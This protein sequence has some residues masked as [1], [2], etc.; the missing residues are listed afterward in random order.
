M[1]WGG[2]FSSIESTVFIMKS[3]HILKKL[4]SANCKVVK[5]RDRTI[6]SSTG[7]K[8]SMRVQSTELTSQALPH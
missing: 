3:H 7:Y 8:Y 5:R 1:N 2:D 6:D 4:Q